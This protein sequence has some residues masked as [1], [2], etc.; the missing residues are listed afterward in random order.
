MKF[1]RIPFALAAVLLLAPAA[2]LAV[3]TSESELCGD[4]A[5][6]DYLD[7]SYPFE[8]ADSVAECEKL[9]RVQGNICKQVANALVDCWLHVV[10]GEM[11]GD[12][13]DCD[14]GGEK[15]I[16]EEGGGTRACKREVRAERKSLRGSFKGMGAGEKQDCEAYVD[17]C[18]ASC[19]APS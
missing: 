6:T 5:P 12:A 1:L 17:E 10:D 9:C 8:H 7:S 3:F 14:G 13:V 16:E 2:A 18:I 15:R 19:D 11:K 4:I